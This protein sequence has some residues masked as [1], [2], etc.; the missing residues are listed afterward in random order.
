MLFG[1]ILVAYDG[2]KLSKKALQKAVSLAQE[3]ST[4]TRQTR[5]EVILVLYHQTVYFGEAFVTIPVVTNQNYSEK[6]Q[7]I[8]DEVKELIYP[9]ENVEII[10]KQGI[11]VT[12]I[13][14]YAEESGADLI[15]M[16][17]RGLGGIKEFF[18]GSVSHN[19]VQQARIPVLIVK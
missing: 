16:G 8:I 1:K 11:P 10:I 7:P 18:L 15:V 19:I 6:I 17:S 4:I 12:T 14:E 5:L 9:L 3:I 2:S 13:L